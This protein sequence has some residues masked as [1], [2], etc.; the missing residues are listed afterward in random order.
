MRDMDESEIHIFLTIWKWW[1]EVSINWVLWN[2]M[3]WA[4]AQCSRVISSQQSENTRHLHLHGYE[5]MQKM[6]TVCSFKTSG[7]GDPTTWCNN[8]E[9]MCF[10]SMKTGLPLIKSFSTVSFPV[11]NA[12]SFLC[13][14]SCVICCSLLSFCCTL[15]KWPGVWLCCGPHALE[16][17]TDFK[18]ML[19]KNSIACFLSLSLSLSLSL[20]YTRTYIRAYALSSYGKV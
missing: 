20:C 1:F 4:V 17:R 13:D 18:W 11:G 2:Q 10:L 15:H 16:E 9:N 5:W 19:L 3:F 8:P 14:L 12:A 6:K 7:S